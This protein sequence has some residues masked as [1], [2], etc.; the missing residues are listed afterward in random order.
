M[1]KKKYTAEDREQYEKEVRIILDRERSG[2]GSFVLAVFVIAVGLLAMRCWFYFHRSTPSIDTHRPVEMGKP[3]V[4]A[5]DEDPQDKGLNQVFP[6]MLLEPADAGI[7]IRVYAPRYPRYEYG[8]RLELFGN[9]S[10]PRNFKSGDGRSFDYIHYLAE[11]DVFYEM[12]HPTM[13]RTGNMSRDSPL[14]FLQAKLIALK[15]AF[16][17]QIM[18]VLGEPHASLAGG[19]VVGEKSSL[20][21]DLIDDFR[22]S[23]L[24]HIVVL[25]G[26]NITVVAV[27][28]RRVL[29]LLPLP[30][31]VLIVL[32]GLAI[33]LFGM[34]VGGGATVV[35]SCLMAIIALSAELSYRKYNA[36]R[37]LGFAAYLMILQNPSIV[38]Y[39]P[40]FQLSF[41]A[42]L[43]LILLAGPFGEWLASERVPGWLRPPEAF[44]IRELVATTLA[45]QV[46]VSP[47]IFYLMGEISIIGILVNIIVLPVIPATMLFVTIVGLG[48]MVSGWI[49]KVFAIPAHFLLGYILSIVQYTGQLSFATVSV[50]MFSPIWLGV[51]YVILFGLI[52]FEQLSHVFRVALAKFA[53]MTS[54]LRFAKKSST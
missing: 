7:R 36:G 14:T 27:A 12:K 32:G 30:R 52:Y 20:G 2:S 38:I 11:Q 19:L 34:L 43:S 48:G 15:R 17:S 22:R 51:S 8:D 29:A 16:L 49:A 10:P 50:P 46:F 54:Q 40:S 4:V 1:T 47:I 45:T 13:H 44:G 39:D 24:I 23:G 37:A 5:I 41:M 18:S 26:F 28:L 3:Y 21:K 25:S 42:T 9:L 33:V 6:V 31:S 53:S 35:R